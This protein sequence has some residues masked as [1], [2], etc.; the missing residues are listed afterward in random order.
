MARTVTR[1]ARLKASPPSVAARPERWG[2]S[3]VCTAWKSCSGA[4]AISSTL[5]TKPARAASVLVASTATTGPLSSACSAAMIASTAAA[6]PVPRRTL[7]SP[8]AGCSSVTG[9]SGPRRAARERNAHG[10]TTSDTSGAA[11]IPIATTVCPWAIPSTTANTNRKREHGLEQH[12]PA[13]EPEA[14]VAGQ[15]AAREVARRVRQ[16]ADHQ[17]PVQRRR[18]VED[19]VADLL[20]P[21]QRD[22]QEERANV[23]WIITGTRS[24]W[25]PR[26]PCARRTEIVCESSCSTGR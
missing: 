16:H 5:N 4:R 2:R 20:A 24:G 7:R 3:E 18:A 23:A 10:T 12:E 15:P 11:A 6:K 9:S 19:L 13:V 25:P 1:I 14:L 22:R 26:R 21:G 8:A 17:H